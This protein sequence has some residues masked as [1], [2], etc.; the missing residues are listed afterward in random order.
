MKRARSRS[1][2]ISLAVSI[3]FHVMI[4]V[5]LMASFEKTIHISAPPAQE[6]KPIIDAVMISKS[7]LQ[8]EIKRIEHKE[9][10]KKE[11]EKRLKALAQKEKQEKLEKIE[12]LKREKEE[13]IALKLKKEA[14]KKEEEKKLAQEKLEKEK[15]AKAKEEALKK[16][17]ALAEQKKAEV[18]KK[19]LE[20]KRLAEQKEK[21][22]AQQKAAQEA[23]Q[24]EAQN[25]VN[26]RVLQNEIT[27]YALLMRNKIHQNWRQPV[28]FDYDGLKCK[29][30]VK[31]LPTGEVVDAT[32]VESSG[33]REF[34]HSSEVAVKKASP[35]PMPEDANIAKEFRQF[36]F[37]FYPGAA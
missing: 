37:T 31:L 33:S 5:L 27:R 7:E 20:E 10:Q 2:K 32:V 14:Q 9:T 18:E 1:E 16:E 28:G 26:K 29:V 8:E 21:E 15:I 19:V 6:Q 23:Q 22:L 24:Q 25:A 12:K 17:K 34:D 3:S 36:T 4:I 11:E 30:L 35:L 13:A